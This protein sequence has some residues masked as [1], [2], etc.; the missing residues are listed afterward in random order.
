MTKRTIL[1][2]EDDRESLKL[3][4]RIL[5]R[6]GYDVLLAS[7]GLEGIDLARQH[8]PDIILTDLNLPDMSGYE[9]TTTL[10][11]DPRFT[12][13]PIVA[14]TAESYEGSYDKAI[15]AGITG[16]LL[17]PVKFTELMERLEYY[18][19][20]G[21]DEIDSER[22][23]AAQIAYTREVATRLESRIR[24]LEAGNAELQKLA[25]LKQNFIQI[26]AH[27]LRTP[28]TLVIGY[29]R[30]LR[31]NAVFCNLMEQDPNVRTLI[32]GLSDAVN[33]M[34]MIIEEIMITSR[35]LSN[36][37]TPSISILNL[38]QLA[39]QV[40]AYFSTA[41][42]ERQITLHFDS[43]GWPTRL[44]GDVEM[45]RIVLNNLV[46]N[47]IK[48]T[49][50]GGHV[51]LEAQTGDVQVTFSV[52]DTGIGIAQENRTKIFEQFNTLNDFNLH[53]SSKTAFRGGGL[54]LGLPVCK[55]IAEAHGGVI[56]AESSRYDPKT[57]PGSRFV[58]MLPLGDVNTL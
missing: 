46:S 23:S 4:H 9:I 18:L 14:L 44:L 1:Y 33:R 40:V 55:G 39:Q 36:Q 41:A 56:Y 34:H 51:Y 52:R 19:G 17:K 38:G 43:G 10:R 6:S 35:I 42:Q 12:R 49:P 48:Y 26:T 30:L 7:S 11:R 20:G 22:L 50:D 57:C 16:Y 37:M 5:E 53:S 54:G 24:E 32:H 45:L 8:V 58:V 3:I 2:I 27:E 21:H 15:A 29:S 31:D 13:L 25:Q 28:L 47:A